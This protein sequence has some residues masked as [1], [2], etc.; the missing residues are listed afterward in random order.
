MTLKIKDIIS[1]ILDNHHSKVALQTQIKDPIDKISPS[2]AIK[3]RINT[4]ILTTIT[5]IGTT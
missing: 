1:R 3:S 4:K 2:Q 5:S